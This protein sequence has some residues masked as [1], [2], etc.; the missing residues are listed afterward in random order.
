L[1]LISQDQDSTL[2]TM[3][4]VYPLVLSAF[5]VIWYFV[6]ARPQGRYVKEK[7][8]MHYPRKTWGVPIAIGVLAWVVY[9]GLDMLISTIPSLYD[10]TEDA[11]YEEQA[12]SPDAAES[13]GAVDAGVDEDIESVKNTSIKGKTLSE[14]FDGW[15]A[16]EESDWSV[17]ESDNKN[18][19]NVMFHCVFFIHNY[20]LKLS[21][22]ASKEFIGTIPVAVV[23]QFILKRDRIKRVVHIDTV[24]EKYYWNDNT[25]YTNTLSKNEVKNYLTAVFQNKNPLNM[26]HDPDSM[27]SARLKILNL[28]K[29]KANPSL[30][31]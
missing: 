7:F 5:W 20:K 30:F 2:D 11:E 10:V 17:I 14:H 16:C 22:V 25:D 24:H 6:S 21:G 31:K 8:G 15:D 29:K 19:V 12:S 4:R 1:L 3:I 23:G 9:L 27:V 26:E 28:Y 13:L 18:E